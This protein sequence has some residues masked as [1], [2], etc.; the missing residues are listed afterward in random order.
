LYIALVWVVIGILTSIIFWEI[1]KYL[2]QVKK[3]DDD[4]PNVQG[5]TGYQ[6]RS[7]HRSQKL[8][9][10]VE[11]RFASKTAP[12][13]TIIDVGTIGFGIAVGFLALLSQG[14]VTGI[15]VIN[16]LNI[17]AL[18]GLGLGIG[19]LRELVDKAAKAD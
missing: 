3:T 11:Q 6:D 1:V 7:K 2:A 16:P 15:R 17:F 18:V 8:S 19:S 5:P 4:Y 14:Y 13:I 9:K 12:R 10:Y